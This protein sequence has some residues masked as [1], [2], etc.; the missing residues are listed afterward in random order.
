METTRP[1]QS[2]LF[3]E[4][5]FCISITILLDFKNV[6][7]EFAYSFDISFHVELARH[8]CSRHISNGAE[9]RAA[10]PPRAVVFSPNCPG[11]ARVTVRVAPV[12]KVSVI[13]PHG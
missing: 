2:L 6:L 4:T 1:I 10:R 13:E 12:K 7:T 9:N 3:A 8:S 11:Y 5:T